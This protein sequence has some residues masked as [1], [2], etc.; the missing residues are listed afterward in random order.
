MVRLTF[1]VI[2][3]LFLRVNVYSM[4]GS[5]GHKIVAQIAKKC[6]DKSIVDSVDYYLDGM[7]WEE[8]SVWM[9]EV[10]SDNSYD[11]MKP[12]HY[13]NVEKDKTYVDTKGSNAVSQLELVIKLLNRKG[14]RDKANVNNLLKVLFHL[15]GDLHQPLHV[16]Y[17]EDKGGN[18]ID[19]DFIGN[20]TNLH[21]VWDTE[22]IENEKISTNM[23]LQLINAIPKNEVSTIQKID[24]VAWMND[25]RTLLPNVYEFEKRLISY[26]YIDKNAQII[27]KQLAKAGIRLASILHQTFKK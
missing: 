23:C 21:K 13:V 24:V 5:K 1:S 8:A 6:L 3:L 27:Q 12:W 20:S 2:L 4:W 22:I 19:V 14:T 7:K 16:G 11:Y 26:K 9:D 10:R 17:A 15:V 25:S 18:T